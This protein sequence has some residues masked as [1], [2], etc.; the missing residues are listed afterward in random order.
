MDFSPAWLQTQRKAH[1]LSQA[2]LAARLGVTQTTISLWENGKN[3]PSADQLATLQHLLPTDAPAP[4][5]APQLN[6]AL[7]T[8]QTPRRPGRKPR[9]APNP[10]APA[11]S[12]AQE[13]RDQTGLERK[14]W[15]A[16]DLLRGTMDAAEY[17]HIVLGLIFIKYIS[18]A[19]SARQDELRAAL[20]DPTSDY[21]VEEGPLRDAE[22]RAVLEDRDEF[23]SHNVFWVP[24]E[25]RWEAILAQAA[26]PG[27]GMFIDRAMAAI[28]RENPALKNTLPRDYGKESL[29]IDRLATLIQRLTDAQ[30]G[31][32][33]AQ[34][35]DVLGRVY[36]YFLSRFA[37]AEGKLG[38]EFYTPSSI[39]RV[40]VEM[41]EPY[42]GRVYDPCCGSG[43][44][45]VQS[46]K[47]IDSHA[48]N[49]P[50]DQRKHDLSIFGQE[51]NLTTWKLCK[52]NLAI[53][54]IDANLGPGHADTFTR[55]LHPDLRADFIL[56]NPPF[57]IS[58]WQGDKLRDDPRWTYGVP[59]T[60]NANYAWMQHII[61]HLAPHGYAAVVMANGSM[62][63]QQSGE[64]DIR[65][66]MV[67]LDI[68][69]CVVSLPGQL[70]YS[71]QIPVCLWFFARNKS[72]A[73]GK[74]PRQG[75]VL[76]IDARKLGRMESRVQ[77]VFDDEHIQHLADTY[78]A[79][80]ARGGAYQDTPGFSR[81]ATRDE[82]KSHDFVMT[83]GRYVGLEEKKEE[84][85]SFAEK[86]FSL[87]VE[88][89]E[90]EKKS[91]QISSKV[92]Q[93]LNLIKVNE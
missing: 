32:G 61:H 80:R 4:D 51:S 85:I 79:W 87:K 26:Q 74:R 12:A 56:A 73:D 92:W 77:R 59:P 78:H 70:F 20:A 31:T 89:F 54:G 53:R 13:V 86:F 8:P 83:P 19:F 40:L 52:M 58:E 35:R 81:S 62:S 68:I 34:S 14:L 48:D 88:L 1:K 69:D 71:T 5:D 93:S 25:A 65:R 9:A 67:E 45:F 47:F 72:G 21:F 82:I 37:S 16:A 38:G 57:N 11:Q 24:A 63:S 66:K 39:V 50:L 42:R 23:A 75:E 29:H 2:G 44:M 10:P 90:L 84:E 55:D 30:L 6:L 17:K 28:E 18:D 15:E 49:R 41:L 3:A 43:G 60:G 22:A 33:R 46:I 7:D 64:G 91:A 76:F 27:L 36:E